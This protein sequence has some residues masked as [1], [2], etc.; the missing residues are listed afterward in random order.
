M[1]SRRAKHKVIHR[2]QM[3]LALVLRPAAVDAEVQRTK[4]AG[5]KLVNPWSMSAITADSC[6]AIDVLR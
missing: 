1:A 5:V 2:A 6:E 4:I 3:C